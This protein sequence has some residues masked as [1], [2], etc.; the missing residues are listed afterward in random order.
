MCASTVPDSSQPL[1]PATQ[2]YDFLHPEELVALAI[3]ED[4]EREKDVLMTLS[5][6]SPAVRGCCTSC[7]G[8]R[9]WLLLILPGVQELQDHGIF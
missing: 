5:S 9:Y 3:P 1:C 6:L 8:P 7:C 4:E 2:S